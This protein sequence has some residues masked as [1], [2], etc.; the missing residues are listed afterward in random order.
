MTTQNPIC[1]YHHGCADGFAAAW[2]VRKFYGADGI[3]FH[4]G[5]YGEAPP[6]TTGRD[7]II[8][9]FSYKRDTLIALAAD[10]TSILIIDHHQT[11]RDDLVDLPENVRTVFDES[12]AGCMLTWNFYFPGEMPPVA[13]DH[14][15]D[16][17]LWRF[18]LLGTK[19]IVG[20]IYSYPMDFDTWD[21]IIPRLLS[22]HQEGATLRRKQD[23]E[24]KRMIAAATRSMAFGSI[25]VPAINAPWWMASDLGAELAKGHPFAVTYYDDA[26]GRRYSLRSTAEGADVAKIAEAFGGGGHKHAAGFRLTRAEAIDFEVA[27][28]DIECAAA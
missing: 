20:A 27:G 12:R 26:D 14:I 10:A 8:V 9:D 6:D 25:I 24:N 13:F 11:S 28:I 21:K 3:D 16:R 23:E 19:E 1:I 2:A 15:E 4:P 5:I 7:V 22:L 18:K 17:D